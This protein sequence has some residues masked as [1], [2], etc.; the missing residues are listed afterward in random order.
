VF[1]VEFYYNCKELIPPILFKLFHKIET[2]GTLPNS[3]CEATIVFIAK[4]HKDPTK[5]EN[6]RV[7]SL[8]KI[9][10]KYSINTLKIN[11]KNT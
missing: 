6:F 9:N 10:A 7:F 11:L 4:T 1:S 8:M 5:K 3:F 2:Q